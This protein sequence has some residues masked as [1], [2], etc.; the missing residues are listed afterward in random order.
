MQTFKASDGSNPKKN[1]Y[2]P[3]LPEETDLDEVRAASAPVADAPQPDTPLAEP[4]MPTESAGTIPVPQQPPHQ[5]QAPMGA[6][7]APVMQQPVYTS[8]Q[9]PLPSQDGQA[10]TFYYQPEHVYYPPTP[11]EYR[12]SHG[13]MGRR[14]FRSLILGLLFLGLAGFIFLI[15]LF[16]GRGSQQF[17]SQQKNVAD[18]VVT[19]PVYEQVVAPPF[20]V[21]G[22]ARGYWYNDDGEFPIQVYDKKDNPVAFGVAI[23]QEEIDGDEFTVFQAIV[24]DY[25][26]WPEK[27][28]GYITLRRPDVTPDMATVYTIPIEFKKQR[29]GYVVGSPIVT[30]GSD[31]E[32]TNTNTNTT[33]TTTTTTNTSGGGDS[34][35]PG[36]CGNGL[37]DD[38]DGL[39]DVQDPECHFD[40]D[41]FNFASYNPGGKELDSAN[42]RPDDPE[43]EPDDPEDPSDPFQPADWEESE[44]VNQFE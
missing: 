11:T 34:L 42:I 25:Q 1:D 2:K 12:E 29:G 7:A 16:G 38:G 37:D 35:N 36:S 31:Q 26:F 10:D 15:I 39:F 43:P 4:A 27:K 5:A 3:F 14:Q 17:Y 44:W 13:G 41:A 21:V 18:I 30:N 6:Q 23:A 33:T 40:F 32:D 8:G 9:A 20:Q 22:R 19:Q 28:D 24:Q